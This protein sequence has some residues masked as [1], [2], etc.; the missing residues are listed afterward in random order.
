MNIY[1]NNKNEYRSIIS[2]PRLSKAH[3]LTITATYVLTIVAAAILTDLLLNTAL[4]C[5]CPP[6]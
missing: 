3:A 6:S 4:E 1:N 2:I 5:R